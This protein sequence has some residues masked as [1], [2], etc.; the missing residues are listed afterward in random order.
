M[1]KAAFQVMRAVQEFAV[2]EGILEEAPGWI[3]SGASK[4]GWTAFLS[5]AVDCETC[6]AKIIA[7]A[8]L[9]PIIPDI[10]ADTHRQWMSYNGFT[11]AFKDYLDANLVQDLDGPEMA[12]LF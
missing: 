11:F 2:K 5:G 8:P 6:A 4:R 7:I 1:V 9:V 12:A 10:L 3:V